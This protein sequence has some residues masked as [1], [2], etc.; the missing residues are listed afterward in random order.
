MRAMVVLLVLGLAGSVPARASSL[1]R[2]DPEA[3]CRKVA[4]AIGAYSAMIDK[5]C[6]EM[7]QQA[8][9]SLKSNW[10]VFPIDAQEHCDEVARAI[11]DEGSYSI[12]K[13]CIEMET[14]AARTKKQFRF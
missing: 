13:G 6:L 9:D 4:T 3:H 2:Y 12:L 10:D 7:E 11:G 8:Y 1:P 14:E 5:G